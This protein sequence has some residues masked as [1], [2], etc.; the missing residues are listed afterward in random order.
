M[1]SSADDEGWNCWVGTGAGCGVQAKLAVNGGGAVAAKVPKVVVVATDGDGG[2]GDFIIA[3]LR[4]SAIRRVCS[5]CLSKLYSASPPSSMD[6]MMPIDESSVNRFCMHLQTHVY[7]LG[8]VKR[9][10]LLFPPTES[11]RHCSFFCPPLLMELLVILASI[12]FTIAWHVNPLYL[13]GILLG[14]AFGGFGNDRT[15]LK[16]A[17]SLIFARLLDARFTLGLLLGLWYSRSYYDG[18]ELT[19]NRR[20]AAFAHF[21]LWA[22]LRRWYRHRIVDLASTGHARPAIA[23]YGCHPHGMLALS[24]ALTFL[25]PRQKGEAVLLPT[26]LAIHSFHVTTPGLREL[27]LWGGCIDATEEAILDTLYHQRNVALV[28]GGVREMGAP[29]RL[30]K[31][32]PGGFLRIAFRIE[33][34]VVPVYLANE[35][36][37]CYVWHGEPRW[38]TGFRAWCARRYRFPFPTFFWLRWPTSVPALETRLGTTIFPADYSHIED[39]AAAYWREL[40]RIQNI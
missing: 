30:S 24:S 12:L 14:M 33:C 13:I 28:P 26:R 29:F 16:V 38:L 40:D 8:Q 4:A 34:P 25:V 10:T 27:T 20:W 3:S 31:D 21:P 1:A 15:L 32:L 17:S 36:K 19:G 5:N 2:G 9:E 23:I 7:C 6:S 39:F 22:M 35:D 37:V 11:L 18:A